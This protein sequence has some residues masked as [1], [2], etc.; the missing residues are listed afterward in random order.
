MRKRSYYKKKE[1]E[2]EFVFKRVD[3]ARFINY[4]MWDGKKTKA[5]KIFYD[6]LDL[7]Q[8]K[9]KEDP[10]KIFETAIENTT[11]IMELVS[12]RI[13]GA[14]YQIPR[15]VRPERKFFLAAH[16]IIK[17]ARA[18]KGKPMSEKLAEEIMASYKK[19]GAAIKK[20]NDTHRMAEANKA[21][22]SLMRK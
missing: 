20:R 11:P 5:E 18:K 8:R 15:E 10:I 17:A 21:F 2:P 7:I 13:G 16:W 6:S 9:L 14:N 22:A 19:E 3:V 1:I 12:R 4:L